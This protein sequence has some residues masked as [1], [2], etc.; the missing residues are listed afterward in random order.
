MVS[1]WETM[2][3]AEE[4]KEFIDKIGCGGQCN[5]RLHHIVDLSHIHGGLED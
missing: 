4:K 5:R 3:D 2:E 1:L